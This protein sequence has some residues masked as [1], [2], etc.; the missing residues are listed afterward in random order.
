MVIFLFLV[1]DE[2]QKLFEEVEKDWLDRQKTSE[3][4]QENQNEDE[5][6]EENYIE[7]CEECVVKGR[8]MALNQFYRIARNTMSMWFKNSEPSPTEVENEFWKHVTEKNHHVCVHSGSIDSSGWGYGFPIGK[9]NTFSKHPWNL[10]VLTNNSGSVLRSLGPLMGVTVPTLHV[11]M[12]FTAFCW[13]RD[14]HGLPWIEYLH[15]GAPK[16][17]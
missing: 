14:P 1:S 8:N 10:K 5:S 9:N 2:R 17:W 15:T 6:E 16:K 12:V 7:E 13:Y 11:G 3:E 4:S